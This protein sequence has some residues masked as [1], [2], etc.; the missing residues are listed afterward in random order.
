MS[1]SEGLSTVAAVPRWVMAQSVPVQALLLAVGVVVISAASKISVPMAPVPVTMQTFAVT[2][3]G[4][5]LGWRLGGL[6]LIVYLIAGAAG[7]PIFSGNVSGLAKL[8]GPSAG[9]LFAFPLAA[10]A[11]GALV[12]SGW[13]RASLVR[14]CA[15]MLLGSAICIVV[16][17]AWLG[18]TMGAETAL[19]KGVLPFLPGAA[20]KS[21][22]AALCLKVAATAF[23]H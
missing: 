13:V 18:V 7:L 10:A 14:L 22:L 16:G 1:Q 15:V 17:A 5:L 20:M 11:I 19:T 21:L 9:Y 2:L 8:T 23:H 4:G 12:E 3:A 6:C